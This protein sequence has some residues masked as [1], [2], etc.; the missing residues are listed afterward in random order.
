MFES[1]KGQRKESCGEEDCPPGLPFLI[2]FI[3]CIVVG[4]GVD[5][6]NPIAWHIAPAFLVFLDMLRVL[7]VDHSQVSEQK[8][9]VAANELPQNHKDAQND[10]LALKL[11]ISVATEKH[12]LKCPPDTFHAINIMAN[13][14]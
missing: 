1:N 14:T 13:V 6:V 10:I 9:E 11:P 7:F 12:G 4:I 3:V 2:F 5:N 8:A